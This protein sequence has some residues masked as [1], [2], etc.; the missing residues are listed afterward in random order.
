MGATLTTVLLVHPAR[1]TAF[2]P[3]VLLIWLVTIALATWKFLGA[4]AL[5][6]TLLFLFVEKVLK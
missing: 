6:Q 3:G 2:L 5:V 4:L 1:T